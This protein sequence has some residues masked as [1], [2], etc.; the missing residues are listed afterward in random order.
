MN[1]EFN[2][3]TVHFYLLSLFGIIL[4]LSLTNAVNSSIVNVVRNYSIFGIIF[5]TLS[6]IVIE[7]IY[8]RV[9]RID[10]IYD[11]Q[12]QEWLGYIVI[13]HWVLFLILFFGFIFYI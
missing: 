13:V 7:Y 5:C 11:N 4:I 8:D 3:K 1:V 6:W 10:P 12:I 9:N 2:Y